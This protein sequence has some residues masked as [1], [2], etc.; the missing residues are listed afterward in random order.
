MLDHGNS[1]GPNLLRSVS[2][3]VIINDCWI[4][5][6]AFYV[7]ERSSYIFSL[8]SVNVGCWMLKQPCIPGIKPIWS[9]CTM[10]LYMAILIANIILRIFESI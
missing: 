7:P 6:N 9:S 8:F 2:F 4:L 5:S 1:F 10:I 3:Y